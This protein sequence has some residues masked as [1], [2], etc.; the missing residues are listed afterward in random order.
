LLSDDRSGDV[1]D[2]R[3]RDGRG[4][5]L[6]R[7]LGGVDPEYDGVIEAA[8]ARFPVD[9]TGGDWYFVTVQLSQKPMNSFEERNEEWPDHM[10]VDGIRDE[11]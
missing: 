2:H 8:C 11:A 6:D 10:V 5:K 1:G 7:R 9:R 3:S 4:R